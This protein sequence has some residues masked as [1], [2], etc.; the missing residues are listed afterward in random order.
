MASNDCSAD[1]H[2]LEYDHYEEEA[3]LGYDGPGTRFLV[4]RCT[5]CGTFERFETQDYQD[6]Q[7][8]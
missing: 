8:W 5:L 1:K 4:Y 7:P 6:T 3:Q 2:N